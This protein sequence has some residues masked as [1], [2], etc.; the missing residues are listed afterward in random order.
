[1]KKALLM[2]VLFITLIFCLCACKGS[3]ELSNT[4]KGSQTD[5]YNETTATVLNTQA[6][7]VLQTE[8]EDDSIF[9]ELFTATYQNQDELLQLLDKSVPT[10]VRITYNANFESTVKI[11]EMVKD[12]RRRVELGDDYYILPEVVDEFD[13]GDFRY[14]I[15][16]NGNAQVVKCLNF[17]PD[18]TIPDE[19]RGYPVAYVGEDLFNK[20]A[21]KS[22]KFGRNITVIGAYAF[23]DCYELE[24]VQLPDNLRI[25][26]STAFSCC[27]KL[28]EISLP[29]SLELIGNCAFEQTGLEKVTIPSNV[30]EIGSWAFAD[31]FNLS[32]LKLENGV[33]GI[34]SQ[35]FA[36]TGIVDLYIPS[37]IT[38]ITDGTVFAECD[39]L[40]RVEFAETMDEDT[41]I[42]PSMFEQCS[43]LSEIKFPSNIVTICGD[44]F[45]G[46][47]SLKEIHIP[48][49]VRKIN[50]GAFGECYFLSDV[51]F[52]SPDCEGLEESGLIGQKRVIHAPK[53]GS[54][55][56]FY[57]RNLLLKFVVTDSV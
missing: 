38:K 55:E 21:I 4:E 26:G 6:E 39:K 16:K 9:D 13:E 54:V 19:A 3:D 8:R 50:Y 30:H 23:E 53:G 57:K 32:E 44:A 1:M 51:Y 22:I 37:S 29:D 43:N 42:C 12:S 10:L 28:S 34:K 20:T 46:C 25:I 33:N 18:I 31:N 35:A 52:E 40:K 36:D 24:K 2:S 5:N 49:S 41:D 48:A 11:E 7:E 56:D 15:H 45:R 47:S 27:E 17:S 14:V